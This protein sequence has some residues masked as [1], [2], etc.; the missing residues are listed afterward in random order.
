[1]PVQFSHRFVYVNT[2]N[3]FY[4][5][6]LQYFY[7]LTDKYGINKNIFIA[8]IIILNT[9][10]LIKAERIGIDPWNLIRSMPAEGEC[11]ERKIK[12]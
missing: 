12:F 5:N 4:I 2:L 10:E 7:G 8:V 11:Y 1:M 6:G 9:G 3:Y